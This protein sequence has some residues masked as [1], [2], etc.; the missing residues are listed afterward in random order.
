[1]VSGRPRGNWRSLPAAARTAAGYRPTVQ[2][3]LTTGRLT[4][5]EVSPAASQTGR[6]VTGRRLETYRQRPRETATGR[7]GDVVVTGL[8]ALRSGSRPRATQAAEPDRRPVTGRREMCAAAEL[9][10]AVIF[11]A[12]VSVLGLVFGRS[13]RTFPSAPSAYS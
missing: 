8:P 11:L 1:M 13:L 6:V 4:G 12:F 2:L 5:R 10:V 9:S 3:A 7:P